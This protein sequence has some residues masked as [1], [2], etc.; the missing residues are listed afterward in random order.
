MNDDAQTL[1]AEAYAD[2]LKTVKET[3]KQIKGS[4]K[5]PAD[6]NAE[7]VPLTEQHADYQRMI[8]DPAYFTSKYEELTARYNLPEE[9]PIPRR[10]VEFAKRHYRMQQ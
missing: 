6:P 4:I 3:T 2:V 10:L 7:K 9:R 5:R 1:F 8:S